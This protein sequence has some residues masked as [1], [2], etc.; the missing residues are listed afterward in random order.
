MTCIGTFQQSLWLRPSLHNLD[1]N[2]NQ[3]VEQ[4][5][6]CIFYIDV[7]DNDEPLF[8]YCPV[9]QTNIPEPGKPT[10]L[11][12]WEPM[13]ATD[14]SGDNP[15]ITCEPPLGS[16]FTIIGQT[17]VRCTAS[18][19]YGNTN[20]CIFYVNIKEQGIDDVSVPLLTTD[21]SVK[22]LIPQ[23]GPRLLFRNFHYGRA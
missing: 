11:V 14:N 19:A 3:S 10:R 21:Q 15:T 6:D 2:L 23:L 5:D 20:S 18:D 13:I 16:Y 17:S 9:N 22:E 12:E 4:N 7:K 1:F 8:A